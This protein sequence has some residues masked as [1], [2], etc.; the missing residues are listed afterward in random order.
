[1]RWEEGL[2]LVRSLNTDIVEIRILRYIRFLKALLVPYD[3]TGPFLQ[4]CRIVTYGKN[5]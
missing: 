5:H 4:A 3:T 2:F 1:M